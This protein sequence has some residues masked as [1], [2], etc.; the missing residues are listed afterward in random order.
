[1]QFMRSFVPLCLIFVL[2]SCGVGS[3]DSLYTG[4]SLNSATDTIYIGDSL[5]INAILTDDFSFD[6]PGN[7]RAS[8][9]SSDEIIATVENGIIT[10]V[11]E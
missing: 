3:S 7:T 5:R 9:A 11:W 1:M 2:S 6:R 10:A 8:W 4:L